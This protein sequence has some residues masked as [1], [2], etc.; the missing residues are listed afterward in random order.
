MMAFIASP[1]VV[2]VVLVYAILIAFERGP[3]M[4]AEPVG[5][6][7]GRTGGANAIGQSLFGTG[8]SGDLGIPAERAARGVELIVRDESGLA[9]PDRP[10]LLL[11][12]RTAFATA[13]A[14]PFVQRATGEWVLRLPTPD[15]ET[16]QSEPLAF[17]FALADGAGGLRP[18]IDDEGTVTGAR[19]LPR[20]TEDEAIADTPL[21]YEFR[22]LGFAEEAAETPDP[23]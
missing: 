15:T 7:A 2:M 17:R 12:N 23:G 20:V 13:S 5:A 21:R 11:T 14:L 19:R 10:I 9:S 18:A 8:D 22:V 16:G 1:L 6:G 3:S 4:V